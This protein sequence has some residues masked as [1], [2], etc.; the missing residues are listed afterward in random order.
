MSKKMMWGLVILI[1]LVVTATVWV[2]LHNNAEIERMK[3]ESTELLPQSD[4][5]LQ[6]TSE[7][8]SGSP[9]YQ[10]PPLGE[11]DDTGYWEGNTWHQKPAPKP[12]KRGFWSEDIDKL[13]HRII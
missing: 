7:R 4:P 13:A 8:V 9:G 12:K 10:P 2:V 11:T 5:S 1:V 3:R 6:H